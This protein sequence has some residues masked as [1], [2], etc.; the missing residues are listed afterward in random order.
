MVDIYPKCLSHKRRHFPKSYELL[1]LRDQ[2]G[3][4]S[5]IYKHKG[6]C[7]LSALWEVSQ[8]QSQEKVRRLKLKE[9]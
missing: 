2:L 7:Q 1:Q 8:E 9:K 4:L 5:S 6:A 3:H